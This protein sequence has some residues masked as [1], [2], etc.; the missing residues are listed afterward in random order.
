M[1]NVTKRNFN[2]AVT[3][4]T[5]CIFY[6][7]RGAFQKIT[8][9]RGGGGGQEK[10]IPIKNERS[11]KFLKLNRNDRQNNSSQQNLVVIKLFLLPFEYNQFTWDFVHSSS[12]SWEQM[13]SFSCCPGLPVQ[14]KITAAPSHISPS[15]V[16]PFGCFL[17]LGSWT[18]SHWFERI[19]FK[20]C[21]KL[22]CI[23][24]D[25]SGVLCWDLNVR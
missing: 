22:M 15:L 21:H 23:N 4:N 24:D 6:S 9:M 5:I 17:F 3:F 11:L 13:H 2:A 10:K 7:R 16:F 25:E 14:A 19:L 8:M 18:F 12:I 20:L 1:W